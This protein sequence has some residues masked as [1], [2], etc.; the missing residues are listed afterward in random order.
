MF[1]EN[2]E[3]VSMN[4]LLGEAKRK[5]KVA[6][7]ENELEINGIKSK[8]TTSQTGNGGFRYW[9]TC[10]TC[11]KRCGKLYRSPVNADLVACRS[12]LSLKYKS[13][14]ES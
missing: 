9:F 8:I 12:C 3:S 7:L 10:P 13:Q 6:L 5:L 1:V 11:T 4:T 2:C 14:Y